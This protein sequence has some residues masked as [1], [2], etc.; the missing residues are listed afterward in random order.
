[1]SLGFEGI[2]YFFCSLLAHDLDGFVQPR[3]VAGHS[4]DVHYIDAPTEGLQIHRSG[5]VCGQHTVYFALEDEILEIR[6]TAMSKKIFAIG[7]LEAGKK[8]MKQLT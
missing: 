1:M 3:A 6:H 8:L 4:A 7:A 2:R 5:T